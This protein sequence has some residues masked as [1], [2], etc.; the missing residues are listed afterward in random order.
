MVFGPL[1]GFPDADAPGFIHGFFQSP[2]KSAEQG[3]F[4]LAELRVP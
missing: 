2:P 1:H 3:A 4:S